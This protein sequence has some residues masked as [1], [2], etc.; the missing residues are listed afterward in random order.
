[1]VNTRFCGAWQGQGSVS[2]GCVEGQHYHGH[3]GV[4][5][6]GR[7]TRKGVPTCTTSHCATEV[8]G[9]CKQWYFLYLCRSHATLRLRHVWLLPWVCVRVAADCVRRGGGGMAG[10][11]GA[12]PTRE[13]R[14]GRDGGDGKTSTS[15][16]LLFFS[17]IP[18]PTSIFTFFLHFHFSLFF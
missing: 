12:G 14:G 6:R 10:N 15:F 5:P 4:V 8:S 16:I 11:L 7:C 1:M 17:F 13:G 2:E 9:G 3:V 18:L